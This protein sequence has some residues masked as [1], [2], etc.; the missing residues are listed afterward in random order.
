MTNFILLLFGMLICNALAFAFGWYLREIHEAI[1][2]LRARLKEQTPPIGAT[3]GAYAPVNEFKHTNQPGV[4]GLV[5]SKTPQR[6]EFEAQEALRQEAR[7]SGTA[8][9]K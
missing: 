5:E 4:V 8:T 7:S 9:Y 1:N 3:L 2:E 6:V